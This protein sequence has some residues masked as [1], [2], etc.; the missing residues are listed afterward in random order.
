[1]KEIEIYQA[2]WKKYM[3][4]ITM[5]LK[6]V[7]RNNESA[8]VGMYQFEF[9]S[10]GKKKRTGYQFDLDLDKGKLKSDISSSPVAKE[11]NEMMKTDSAVKSLL[12]SGHFNFSLNGDFILTIQ[13]KD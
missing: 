13:K 2:V 12:V 1:M 6:Q 3:P 10:S 8:H 11:L 7:I 4:V 5:K 9:H